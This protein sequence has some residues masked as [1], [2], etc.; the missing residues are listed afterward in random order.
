MNFDLFPNP[1]YDELYPVDSNKLAPVYTHTEPAPT[2]TTREHHRSNRGRHKKR[3]YVWSM[4]V[5]LVVRLPV[6]TTIWTGSENF[7]MW[8]ILMCLF[9]CVN[10][11]T[12][13]IKTNTT[14]FDCEEPPTVEPNATVLWVW[15]IWATPVTWHPR[16]NRECYDCSV[17]DCSVHDCSVLYIVLPPSF[18]YLFQLI[19][20][21]YFIILPSSFKYLIEFF[22]HWYTYFSKI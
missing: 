7:C 17:Y 8:C 9:W 2:T 22:F 10:T 18:K 20:L 5:V 15:S 1:K 12:S 21:N 16:C 11:L 4:V 19:W 6:P 14:F 3:R 13:L